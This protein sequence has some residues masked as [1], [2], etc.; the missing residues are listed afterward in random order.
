M[1]LYASSRSLE[2][3]KRPKAIQAINIANQYTAEVLGL[4][5]T[6]SQYDVDFHDGISGFPVFDGD[7]IDIGNMEIRILETPGHSPCSIS[8]YVPELKALFPSDACGIPQKD[9]PATYGTSNF[10]KFEESLRKLKYL[11]IDYMC[12]DHGGYVTGIEAQDFVSRCI[13]TAKW[14]RQLMAETY[15]RTGN[16]D[17]A[18]KRLASSF[19][20]ENLSGMVPHSTFVESFRQ[21]ILDIQGL[22]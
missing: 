15:K 2:I 13:Q 7:C 16:V 4:R 21:M 14:R 20:K 3:F 1:V 18:A 5:E 17:E 11:E 8:A 9:G 10:T 12:S 6:C 19:R 22:K